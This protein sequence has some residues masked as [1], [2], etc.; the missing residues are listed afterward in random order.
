MRELKK[1]KIYRRCVVNKALAELYARGV[2]F[3]SE[4]LGFCRQ[5]EKAANVL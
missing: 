1:D 4:Y 5:N 2:E 3:C